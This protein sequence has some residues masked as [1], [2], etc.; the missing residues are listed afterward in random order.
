MDYLYQL[1]L[2]FFFYSFFGWVMEVIVSLVKTH[3]FINRGFLTGP[4]CPIYGVGG[5]L[6][7]ILLA[8]YQKDPLILY[9]MSMIVAS[10]LEYFT[11]Y[12][13]EKIFKNRWWDYSN[14]KYNINGRVCLE[15][16]VPFGFLAVFMVYFV[17][18]FLINILSLI[19]PIIIRN[20][21]IILSAITLIDIIVSFNIII[22]LKNVSN[23]LRYDSTE[24]ITKKVRSIL[25]DKTVFHRRLLNSFPDMQIFNKATVLKNKLK[26]DKIKLKQNKIKNKK[27]KISK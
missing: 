14:L 26:K 27:K 22:T 8:K 9:F 25:F 1:I 3:H 23:S 10:I 12:I 5:I 19:D 17:N 4:I 16:M 13:M 21:A 18:P 15:T 6:I 2:I 7:L 20:I 24:I 11:S